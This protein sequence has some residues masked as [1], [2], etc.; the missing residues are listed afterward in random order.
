M[1]DQCLRFYVKT[2]P[3]FGDD[4][5]EFNRVVKIAYLLQGLRA[6]HFQHH[7]EATPVLDQRVFVLDYFCLLKSKLAAYCEREGP[8]DYTDIMTLTQNY[9]EDIRRQ[10]HLLD[11]SMF[12]ITSQ[13]WK[14][15]AR[16][17]T[18]SQEYSDGRW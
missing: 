1:F 5:C 16:D 10:N 3:H 9:A 6:P 11:K 14:R 7:I 2:G 8:N 17:V 12:S 13:I 15:I 4:N 18:G